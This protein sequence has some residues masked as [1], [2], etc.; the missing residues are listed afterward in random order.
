MLI[1]TATNDRGLFAALSHCWG[2]PNFSGFQSPKLLRSNLDTFV[3][4]GVPVS[5]LSL[6]FSDAIDVC[7]YLGYQYLWI[8]SLCI[9]QDDNKDWERECDLMA[10]VYG[11]ADLVIGAS[12]AAHGSQ[13]FLGLRQGFIDGVVSLSGAHGSTTTPWQVCY[14]TSLPHDPFRE[15]RE[16]FRPAEEGPL[17][18]RAWAYQER[19]LS[20]RFISFGKHEVCWECTSLLECECYTVHDCQD[21]REGMIPTR[22]VLL[23]PR[24][25]NLQRKLDQDIPIDALLHAWRK[26]VV[27]R[28]T[29]LQLTKATD[30]LA[31]LSAIAY[32]F[33]KRIWHPYLAGIW[34]SDVDKRGLLWGCVK[35][36]N[37]T[38]PGAPSWSWASV[39]GLVIYSMVKSVDRTYCPVLVGLD[40]LSSSRNNFSHPYSSFLRFQGK[41]M[42]GVSVTRKVVQE[43][44]D[45]AVSFKLRVP[46]GGVLQLHMDS[47]IAKMECF[48]ADGSVSFLTSRRTES[49]DQCEL[50]EA[51]EQ[52]EVYRGLFCFNIAA[53]IALLLARTSTQ[54][55]SFERLGLCVLTGCDV[56]SWET[57]DVKII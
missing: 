5:S 9:I 30:R 7:R 28:Y 24:K 45:R 57:G 6:S 3:S 13:G 17:E 27:E 38:I 49:Q 41:I 39:H 51:A 54:Q 46:Q 29:K 1:L 12:S 10:I 52:R 20:K 40:Q 31:A 37:G 21:A 36:S 8:D 33:S 19:I 55:T 25:Y 56:G 11:N 22:T 15:S 43:Q 14:R 2:D 23:P 32:Q 47:D 42:S 35:P 34:L 44:H 26:S 4:T 48:D 16:A 50:V 53:P 18:S